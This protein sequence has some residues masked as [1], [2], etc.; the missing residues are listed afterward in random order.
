MLQETSNSQG[1]PHSRLAE[2]GSRKAIQAR[3]DHPNRVVSPSRGLPVDMH[4]VAPTSNR[5][6]CNEVQQ[7]TSVSPVLDSLA[8]TMD[9]L[10]LPWEDLNPYVF[11]P[12][13]ILDKVVA[14]LRDYSCRRIILLLQG[15]PTCPWTWWLY[16]ARSTESA[17]SADLTL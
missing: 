5:P 12:V 1:L 2:C 17:Q 13:A 16:Q 15:S 7:V 4:Q 9:A 3:P 11:T 10:S 8:W 14:K 6:F